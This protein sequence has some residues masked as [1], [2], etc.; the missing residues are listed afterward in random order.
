MRR[1]F[2]LAGS[3]AAA[4]GGFPQVARAEAAWP[5][6]PIRMVIP[7]TPGGA[8]D[9]MARLTAQKMSERLGVNVVPEN[10]AG[11]SGT[12]G[13]MAVIQSPADGYTVLF[14][15][16][17]H[18]LAR[19]VMKSVPY[20]PVTDFTPVAR[21]G[22]GPM[23]LVMPPSLPQTTIT[24]VVADAKAHPERWTFA[25]SG[26][27]SAGH[28]ASIAFNQLA[29]LNLP[30]TPYRGSSP[31][32]ADIAA[33]NIQ[34]MIDPILA[35][36]PLARGGQVRALSITTEQRSPVAP[37]I[38]TGAEAGMPGLVGASWYGVWGPRG[39][40]GEIVRKINAGLREAMFEPAVVKRLTELG[41][42]PVA[43][44]PEDFARF[45]EADVARNTTLLRA[46]NFQP[47]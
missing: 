30:I 8:T 29:G 34:L 41:F 26:L 17:I 31:A 42:E 36:L 13:S 6:R 22:R 46:A 44:S 15:A 39:L 47:E 2:L 32:L 20:D 25:T 18:V 12:V 1:R 27:G 40:P 38:P 4:L 33:G 5:N 16:S 19:L 3:G 28:L 10:R 21:V 45:I 14:S 37:E 9:A 43:E 7:Y 24:E 35:T 11:G 23:L